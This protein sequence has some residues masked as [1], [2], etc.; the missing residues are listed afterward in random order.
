MVVVLW[1]LLLRG[2]RRVDA[3][4]DFSVNDIARHGQARGLVGSRGV[5]DQYSDLAGVSNSG[6]GDV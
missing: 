4:E 3:P 5:G 2:G 1:V 6:E